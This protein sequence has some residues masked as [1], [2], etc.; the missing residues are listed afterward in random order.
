LSV[1]PPVA[2]AKTKPAPNN[3]ASAIVISFFTCSSLWSGT[4]SISS[5]RNYIR[6]RMNRN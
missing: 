4:I 2:C 6:T 5:P 1:E 3:V